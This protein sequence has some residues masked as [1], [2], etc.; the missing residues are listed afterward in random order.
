[1]LFKINLIGAIDAKTPQVG[2]RL[3]EFNDFDNKKEDYR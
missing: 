3:A 2:K 1:M